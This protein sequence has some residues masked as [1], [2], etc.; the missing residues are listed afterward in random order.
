[1]TAKEH[2]KPRKQNVR[3][4]GAPNPAP[5]IQL[6]PM[7]DL[8]DG[9]DPSAIREYATGHDRRAAKPYP[10]T[11]RIGRHDT[12]ERVA[13]RLA[14][15]DNGRPEVT[16]RHPKIGELTIAARS[17]AIR[18]FALTPYGLRRR[19]R[20][21]ASAPPPASPPEISAAAGGAP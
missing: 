7:V 4:K 16:V 8:V 20:M 14:A 19:E 3:A 10:V 9:I 12:G 1:M 13:A 5:S 11:V 15:I 18:I 17:P 2:K 21:P 6:P